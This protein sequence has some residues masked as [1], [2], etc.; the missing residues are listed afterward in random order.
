MAATRISV[1]QSPA[2][3]VEV[4]GS[5]GRR[6]KTEQK[7]GDGRRNNWLTIAHGGTASQRC[8]K[9]DPRKQDSDGDTAS[10]RCVDREQR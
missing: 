5:C 3:T 10:E 7:A 6:T 4:D 9:D 8:I 1:T 2:M